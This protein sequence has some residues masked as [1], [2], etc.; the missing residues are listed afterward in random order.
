VAASIDPKPVAKSYPTVELYPMEMAAAGGSGVVGVTGAAELPPPQPTATARNKT[1][2]GAE[3]IIQRRLRPGANM[4][5]KA[6]S[7]NPPLAPTHPAR[8]AATKWEFAD[9]QP[10]EPAVQ[11]TLLSPVVMSWK[12]VGVAAASG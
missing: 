10:V 8:L 7:R 4:E 9:V 11:G 2:I 3:T 1:M 5:T 12:A 6:S